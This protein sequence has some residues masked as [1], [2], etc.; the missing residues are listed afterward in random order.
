[1]NEAIQA[2]ATQ[3]TTGLE[4]YVFRGGRWGYERL[5]LRPARSDRICSSGH[6][7]AAPQA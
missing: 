4:R 6:R 1:M 5:R 7:T 3:G 2:A